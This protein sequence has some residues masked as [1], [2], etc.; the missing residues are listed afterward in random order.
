[1]NPLPMEL[2]MDTLPLPHSPWRRLQ[3][4]FGVLIA[5]TGLAVL[6][7]KLASL[8]AALLLAG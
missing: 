8:L 6:L 2:K 5:G 3:F 1:M 4:C 7:E